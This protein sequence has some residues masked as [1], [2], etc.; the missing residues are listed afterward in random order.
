[1]KEI[2]KGKL[3]EDDII[4]DSDVIALYSVDN[5]F[6]DVC[7]EYDRMLLK[8]KIH[9]EFVT[10]NLTNESDEF[11]LL[12]VKDYKLKK[13]IHDIKMKK[14]MFHSKEWISVFSF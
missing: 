2:K 6:E 14:Y 5:N 12:F 7:N 1:M 9:K 13:R 10:E 3:S 11:F 8:F 4:A